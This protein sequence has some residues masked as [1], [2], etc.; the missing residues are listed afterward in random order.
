MDI[1]MQK[2]K[3][4]PYFTPLTKINS[5]WIIDLYKI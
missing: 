5:K 2:K 4:D 1:H 3:N